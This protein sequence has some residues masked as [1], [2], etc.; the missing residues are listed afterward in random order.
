MDFVIE[1]LTKEVLNMG[2]GAALVDECI[3]LNGCRIHLMRKGSG[4]PLLWLH[5]ANGNS[6]WLPVFDLLAEHY[7][8]I[9][10]EHPGFGKSEPSEN[11]KDVEDLVYFYRAFLDHMGISKI[12]IVGQ[13]LGG[14]IAAEFAI[15]QTHRV[16]KLVL[17]AAAGLYVPGAER[18]DP[19]MLNQETLIDIMYCDQHLAQAAKEK[20]RTDEAQNLFIKNRTAFARLTW[21]RFFNPKLQKYLKW[22]D[23]PTLIVWGEEDRVISPEHGKVFQENIP[24]AQLK[25]IPQCGHLPYVEKTEEYAKI[26]HHFIQTS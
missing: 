14:W 5:G 16:N 25:L 15:S 11:I 4:E 23:V 7:D 20:S 18:V 9:V 8:V 26:I 21:D 6:T 19:F 22:I 3:D 1:N 13:S 2:T 10:P 17:T 12:H 24:G